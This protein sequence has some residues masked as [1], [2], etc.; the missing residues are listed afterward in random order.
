MN[1]M[2]LKLNKRTSTETAN[3]FPKIQASLIKT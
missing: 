2:H 1:N 3:K